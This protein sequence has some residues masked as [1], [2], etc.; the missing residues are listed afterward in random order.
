[1]LQ[2]ENEQEKEAEEQLSF[3]TEADTMQFSR[4]GIKTRASPLPPPGRDG[5]NKK[6]TKPKRAA[7]LNSTGLITKIKERFFLGCVV[8]GER[9]TQNQR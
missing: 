8:K 1:M 4:H 9:E 2:K 5:K 6:K 7:Q 3:R